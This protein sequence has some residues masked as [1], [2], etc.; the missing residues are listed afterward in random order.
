[1]H[2]ILVTIIFLSPFLWNSEA[3]EWKLLL[4]GLYITNIP[5]K[6]EITGN[7]KQITVVRIDPQFWELVFIGKS[8][9]KEN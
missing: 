5:I 4:T 2:K 3:P 7:I 6:V 1:M 8:L 9:S